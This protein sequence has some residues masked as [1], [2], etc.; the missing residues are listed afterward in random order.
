MLELECVELGQSVP[1]LAVQVAVL[2]APAWKVAALVAQE[3]VAQRPVA[4]GRALRNEVPKSL[5]RRAA[6]WHSRTVP[7]ALYSHTPG[8][9]WLFCLLPPRRRAVQLYCLAIRLRYSPRATIW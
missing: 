8:W 2:V 5:A 6:S 7:T 9:D 4:Q 3:P 1:E